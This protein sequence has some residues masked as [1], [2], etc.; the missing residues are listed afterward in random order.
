MPEP[1]SGMFASDE[2]LAAFLAR[3]TQ[4]QA[5]SFGGTA[6]LAPDLRASLQGHGGSTPGG[7]ATLGMG[8]LSLSGGLDT[9][10]GQVT[11]SFGAGMNV[12][13][14]GGDASARLNITPDQMKEIEMA[15]RHKLLGGD[16]GATFNLA[17]PTQ[18]AP[19]WG[20]GV[21]GR[22]PF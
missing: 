13:L 17:Q 2:D 5:P 8:P 4:P 22:I 18:G 3:M 11:P 7:T 12:P 15:Y 14:A 20:V 1:Q 10:S 6:S 16:I 9:S 21:R 19:S